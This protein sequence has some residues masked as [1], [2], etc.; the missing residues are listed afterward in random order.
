MGSYKLGCP[1]SESLKKRIIVIPTLTIFHKPFEKEPQPPDPRCLNAE[2]PGLKLVAQ[3]L[4]HLLWLRLSSAF[5][6]HCGTQLT[7][8]S[9]PTDL[10]PREQA[11]QRLESPFLTKLEAPCCVWQMVQAQ[12]PEALVA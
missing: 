3:F 5:D 9:M 2:P 1:F 6:I 10:Q 11:P 12:E 8:R 7:P 4:V